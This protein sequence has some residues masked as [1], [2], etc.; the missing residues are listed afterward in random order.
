MQHFNLYH[1]LFDTP[2]DAGAN[3][4]LSGS[5]PFH[6]YIPW[7]IFCLA[8]ILIWFYYTVEGRK[9]FVKSM[10]VTKYMF[11]RFLGWFA[12]ICFIGLPLIFSRAYL[13]A[14]FFAWRFWRVLWGAGI[15]AWG[16]V[17]LVY[18]TRK[19]PQERANFIA[20]QNQQRYVPK[21]KSSNKRKT[22]ALT[23]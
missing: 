6:F 4:G 20:Y 10:P 8:G 11:D 2:A 13:D 9:R 7:L 17:W 18:L 16:I 1:W 15:L 14:Y 12:V 5:E 21:A 22:K 3:A 19:Y 23:R